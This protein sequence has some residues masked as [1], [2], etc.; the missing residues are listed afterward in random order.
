LIFAIGDRFTIGDMISAIRDDASW[1]G[2]VIDASA[3]ID[4][5]PRR[6]EI[7]HRTRNLLSPPLRGSPIGDEFSSSLFG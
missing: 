6:D 7:A 4:D 1:G 3:R 5:E 2:H